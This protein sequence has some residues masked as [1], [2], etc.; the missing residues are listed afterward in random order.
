MTAVW[1]LTGTIANE[2]ATDEAGAV[3]YFSALI[4]HV[5][6]IDRTRPVTV[7]TNLPCAADKVAPLLDFVSDAPIP[8]VV[9]RDAAQTPSLFSVFSSIPE[10]TTRGG[11]HSKHAVT[12]GSI[13]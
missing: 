7:A 13:I 3:P 10:A 4:E 1:L 11:T 8:I 6:Q 2:A 9:G 12:P 5:K